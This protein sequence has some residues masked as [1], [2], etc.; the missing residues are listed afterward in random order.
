LEID[1]L[2]HPGSLCGETMRDQATQPVAL[3]NV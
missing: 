1:R 3:K 2:S